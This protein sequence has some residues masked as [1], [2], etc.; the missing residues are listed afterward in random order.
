MT[1]SQPPNTTKTVLVEPVQ[2]D[3]PPFDMGDE[4]P[5]SY[6]EELAVAANTAELQASLGA[7]FGVASAYERKAQADLLK[8]SLKDQDAAPLR[9]FPVAYAAASF[10]RA[11]GSHLA[12]DV[13]TV[14]S[15]ITHKLL[16]L[17]DCGDPKYELKALE[18]LGKHSDIGLFTERSEV[19][20][21]Y[22]DPE[23]L[24]NAI[25]E[26]VKRLLNADVIDAVP[27]YATIDDELG[28]FDGWSAEK[29][30]EGVERK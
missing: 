22:K 5:S 14:R 19:T 18:L 21:N 6:M 12:L 25:K 15:A 7:D 23:S 3:R 11:Y 1:S 2:G 10:L 4:N 30:A 20:I 16:S 26:R 8:K 28:H 9:S 29:P 17:A 13:A 24:E 27:L